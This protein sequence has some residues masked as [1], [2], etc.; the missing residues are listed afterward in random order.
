MFAR[1]AHRRA[2]HKHKIMILPQKPIAALCSVD[3][4][5]KLNKELLQAGVP[6]VFDKEVDLRE[7]FRVH[8]RIG[9][10]W[11]YSSLLGSLMSHNAHLAVPMP[12]FRGAFGLPTKP[13]L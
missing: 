4:A 3:E 11:G 10:F 13:Q 9:I 5:W 2:T 7:A 8:S 6:C 1:V 12:K